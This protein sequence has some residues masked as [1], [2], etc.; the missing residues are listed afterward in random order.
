MRVVLVA[1]GAAV[2]A[3][4]GLA[5]AAGAG[6]SHAQSVVRVAPNVREAKPGGHGGH[7]GQPFPGWTSLNWSGYAVQHLS[8]YSGVT[9][10][11]TVPQVT[12]CS[13][14]GRFAA[15]YSAAWA[16]IDG[17]DNS[18]LIQTG[19]EQD[20]SNSGGP[21]YQAWWTTSS[22][23]FLEQPIS[24]GCSSG[25][26]HCGQVAAGDPMTATISISS[27]AATVTLTDKSTS[28]GWTFSPPSP[29]SYSGPMDSAEW[30]MEAPT[31]GGSIATLPTY[32][33]FPFDPNSVNGNSSPALVAS[34]GGELVKGS[35]V[36]SIPST[37]D[38]GQNEA[39]GFNM[40]YGSTAPNPPSS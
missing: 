17:F 13:A 4:F 32:N 24:S 10:N 33:T 2:L 23:G 9:G 12:G 26:A 20:Y 7:G 6:S 3:A 25:E 29:I 40:A 28:H 27:G 22:L 35:T 37:P 36:Y 38:T 8:S 5:A 16:G 18:S 15:C 21:S 31:V 30:I 14:H 34:D 19:T 39:D 11:W 1:I